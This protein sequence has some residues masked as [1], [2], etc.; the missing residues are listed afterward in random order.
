MHLPKLAVHVCLRVV[1]FSLSHWCVWGRRCCCV[2][3]VNSGVSFSLLDRHP[4][5][6]MF[7]LLP[8]VLHCGKANQLLF[9]ELRQQAAKFV[10]SLAAVES[11][12]ALCVC[13]LSLFVFF[14]SWE[15][16]LPLWSPEVFRGLV[17]LNG[18]FMHLVFPPFLPSGLL[19]S[20]FH[21]RLWSVLNVFVFFLFFYCTWRY[22]HLLR[23]QSRCF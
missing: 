11:C 3:C 7:C 4:W 2:C 6:L 8:H 10:M 14:T 17:G 21:R 13:F 12:L 5:T 20:K 22:L 9:S 19:K 1:C 23:L 18:E 16:P 15:S